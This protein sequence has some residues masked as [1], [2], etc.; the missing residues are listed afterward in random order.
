MRTVV[1]RL[2]IS[3]VFYMTELSSMNNFMKRVKMK[4]FGSQGF[5]T[6]VLGRFGSDVSFVTGSALL[7]H[8]CLK[9]VYAVIA[10]FEYCHFSYLYLRL[11]SIQ[12]QEIWFFAWYNS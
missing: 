4:A 1:R 11:C 9:W 3:L 5:V 2:P 8:L 6:W 7:C 12:I 10:E